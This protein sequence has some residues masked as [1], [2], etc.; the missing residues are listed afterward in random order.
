MKKISIFGI[1]VFLAIF[2]SSACGAF[3]ESEIAR[4]DWDRDFEPYTGEALPDQQSIMAAFSQ[5]Y[6]E[7]PDWG[8]V[9]SSFCYTNYQMNNKDRNEAI[10]WRVNTEGP[11]K[12]DAF[13]I[14][15]KGKRA[16]RK[17]SLRK[18]GEDYG[19]AWILF[20]HTDTNGQAI[21]K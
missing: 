9:H 18:I 17:F 3:M 10:K 6:P 8:F 14:F 7:E 15:K 20:D 4:T 19:G 1:V 11:F 21:R 2:T 16:Y 5:L 12:V 13:V